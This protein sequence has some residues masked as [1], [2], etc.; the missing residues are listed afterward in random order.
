[1]PISSKIYLSKNETTFVELLIR[2]LRVSEGDVVE[3]G[4]GT[5]ST[6]LLHWLCKDMDRR[7]ISYENDIDFYN[8]LSLLKIGTP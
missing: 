3:L 1:M 5:T 2:V 4:T 8:L 7:L 6:P